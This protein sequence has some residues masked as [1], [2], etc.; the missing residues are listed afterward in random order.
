MG[1]FRKLKV[2]SLLLRRQTKYVDVYA[3][4]EDSRKLGVNFIT[5]GFIGLFATH[6]T[7][8][9]PFI[10]ISLIWVI[11]FGVFTELLGLYKRSS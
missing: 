7:D 1:Q 11:L 9:T 3:F 10:V 4:K 2:L 5:A 6:A 8:M